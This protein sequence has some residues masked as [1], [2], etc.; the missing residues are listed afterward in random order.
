MR[1]KS[2]VILAAVT[3]VVTVA[4]VV[5]HTGTPTTTEVA[6]GEKLF[7]DLGS[8]LGN[9]TRI[10]VAQHGESFAIV[11]EADDWVLRERAGYRVD[12]NVVKRVL[13][14]LVEME[15]VE[16]KTDKPEAYPRIQV[17]DVTAKAAKSIQIVLKDAAGK[18]VARLLVGK[19]RPSRTA[20]DTDRLYVRRPGEA[21][22]W[23][24]KSSLS[25]E[26][27]PI[28]WLD[29]KVV[30]IARDRVVRVATSQ[31]DGSRLV[32]AKDKPGED[33]KF[34]IQ[35]KVPDGMKPKSAGDLAA[36]A[37]ALA[38]L[39]LDDVKRVADVD[40]AKKPVGEAQYTTID[41]LVV[42]VRMSEVDGTVWSIVSASVD[43]SVR[44]APA[45]SEAETKSDG[46]E[47]ADAKPEEDKAAADKKPADEPAKPAIKPLD[48]VRK[49]AEAI[50][51][52]VKGWAY[53][54]PSYA[55]D[56]L[57]TKMADMVEKETSS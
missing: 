5:V 26:K 6:A 44:P 28:R 43:E 51:A 45:K 34:E 57:R 4:A 53:K 17:E 1:L 41:G 33:G 48:E 54:L 27:D 55:L 35:G 2:F 18:D 25:L 46:A 29:R 15:T 52:R 10:E 14:A 7:P 47:K 19:S 23:L 12:P 32:L 39:D 31:P 36:P 38:S 42:S 16:A 49:E 56:Q 37:G 21:Q 3:A 24:V 11:R 50:N 8:E 13:S 22:S 20:S 30:D 9:V 40:F